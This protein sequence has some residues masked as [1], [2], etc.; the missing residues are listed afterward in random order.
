VGTASVTAHAGAAG[1]ATYARR[2]VNDLAALEQMLDR[3]LLDGGPRRIGAEQEMLLIRDDCAPAPVALELLPRIADARLT[4]ELALFN[5]E[6]NL[7]PRRLGVECLAG[8]YGEL[9]DVCNHARRAAA[10]CGAQ[11]LITGYLPTYEPAAAGMHQMVPS[12]RFVE[13]NGASTAP[14]SG[15]VEFHI[16]GRDPLVLSHPN[17]LLEGGATSFQIHLQVG[18]EEFASAFNCALLVA[19]PLVAACSN[20]PVVFGHR[21][22]CETRVPL[23]EASGDIRNAGQWR[24]PGRSRT[25]L[26]DGWIDSSVLEI[27]RRDLCRYSPVLGTSDDEALATEELRDGRV[28]KLRALSA[29]N[30]TVWRWI[31]PC[32]GVTAG[33][34]HLRIENRV[35]PAGP[36]V[37]D[38]VANAAFWI[39]LMIALP[40]RLGD[41]ASRLPFWAAEENFHIAARSGLDAQL[42]WLDGQRVAVK[43]LLLHTLVPAAR[44]GL[45]AAGV[46]TDDAHGWIEI[47][48]ARV[49]SG[50]TG[51]RWIL[52]AFESL[53]E[54]LSPRERSW[55]VTN[56]LARLCWSD[57]PVHTWPAL[58]TEVQLPVPPVAAA[59]R[60]D[61]L[62]VD[63]EAP[64]MLVERQA[65]WS[66][67]SHVVVE[68]PSGDFVGIV[69][70]E[71]LRRWR[72]PGE[73][74]CE[75]GALLP[76]TNAVVLSADVPADDALWTMQREQQACAVVLLGDHAAGVVLLED[77]ERL[78]ARR[79]AGT[80]HE[81]QA[82]RAC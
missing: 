54:R 70:T 62:A 21:L 46:D 67:A 19:A 75:I 8:L 60:T 36:T 26:G 39:G 78:L 9:R 6:A 29:F 48:R 5:L 71:D 20:S 41:V 2:L 45:V 18:A 80:D 27:F 3:G 66:G 7:T 14:R 12:A 30:G 72:E 43:D 73:D 1:R 31:R 50:R 10:E 15:R 53:P 51:S 61:F 64:A 44:E 79:P 32:Y 28:P 34:P 47:V 69:A 56:A 82:A 81:A 55:A 63:P 4:T 13:M 23:L 77:L 76:V 22:W 42:R 74:D 37:C 24:R 16:R 59:M 58:A 11:A 38:E 33:S 52:D 25:R 17:I 68:T 49:A 35:L 57:S 65:E 40:H